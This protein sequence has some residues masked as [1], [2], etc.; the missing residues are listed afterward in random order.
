MSRSPGDANLNV[1]QAELDCAGPEFREAAKD[2]NSAVVEIHR[3]A[4]WSA[5]ELERM[6]EVRN[7]VG[8]FLVVGDGHS[9]VS[10]GI[11]ARGPR[12]GPNP[13]SDGFT[14]QPG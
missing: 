6:G 2:I 13:G 8:E 11:R 12:L 4:K 10:V 1:V 7:W 3:V 9:H 5:A 14:L